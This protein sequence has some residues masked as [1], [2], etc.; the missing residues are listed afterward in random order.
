LIT[1]SCPPDC[2]SSSGF[3]ENFAG[4]LDSSSALVVDSASC[5]LDLHTNGDQV[6]RAMADLDLSTGSAGVPS[7]DDTAEL[8]RTPTPFGGVETRGDTGPHPGGQGQGRQQQEEEEGEGDQWTSLSSIHNVQ[9]HEAETNG[10]EMRADVP[11]TSTPKRTGANNGCIPSPGAEEE[12]IAEGQFEGS[13]YNRDGSRIG[14]SSYPASC[15]Y[16]NVFYQCL[17]MPT[18][19]AVSL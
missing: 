19:L 18:P 6:T 1:S 5:Y 15:L 14:R 13:A 4:Q 8:L 11:A 17:R 16:L 2:R 3:C 12:V 7:G 9:G 10:M